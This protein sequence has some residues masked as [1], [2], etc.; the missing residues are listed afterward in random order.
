MAPPPPNTNPYAAPATEGGGNSP[1]S[2][3]HYPQSAGE[4]ARLGAW[5][6]IKAIAALLSCILVVGVAG[7][8]VE[9][10]YL[11]KG[12]PIPSSAD[13]PWTLVQLGLGSLCYGF[14]GAFLGATVGLAGYC[15]TGPRRSK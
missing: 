1:A 6:G 15:F 14:L 2:S 7:T 5:T 9:A 11:G 3:V 4:A 13:L 8:V 12:L 10:L